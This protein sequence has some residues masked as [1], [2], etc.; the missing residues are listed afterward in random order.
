[1]ELRKAAFLPSVKEKQSIMPKIIENLRADSLLPI[2]EHFNNCC[3]AVH[4]G[5]HTILKYGST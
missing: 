5:P 4:E 3:T 2:V 1:M